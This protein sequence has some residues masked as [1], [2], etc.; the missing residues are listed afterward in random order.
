MSGQDEYD[1]LEELIILGKE[2]GYLSSDEVKDALPENFLRSHNLD[3]ILLFLGAAGIE[4]LDAERQ[5]EVGRG[6]AVRKNANGGNNSR[7]EFE[8][9]GKTDDPVRL[10][11]REM[12]TVPLLN[13]EAEIE[14]AK[15][16]EKAQIN[17]L[18]AVSRSPLAVRE[19]LSC[20]QNLRDRKIQ[21]TKLVNF[22]KD[23]LID[24]IL[25][26]RQSE[27]HERISRVRELQAK[28][29]EVRKQLRRTSQD[30]PEYEK[31]L[32]QLACYRVRIVRQIRSL[33]L[34]PEIQARLVGVVRIAVDGVRALEREQKQLLELQKSPLPVARATQVK[35]RLGQ[36]KKELLAIDDELQTTSGELKR[37]FAT[38]RRFELEEDIAKKE[39][40]EANLRLVVSIAKKYARR[41]VL[42]LDLIQEGNIGLM[43]AVDK[44]D[45]RRGYKFSTY[46]H[47]WIRQAITRAI[48]D[49]S[50]TIRLPVHM[51]ER[52]NKLIQTSRALLQQG[53]R[54]PTLEELAHET[55]IPVAQVR[56]ALKVAQQ[57]ISLETP[58][59]EDQDS[60]LGS[61]VEDRLA[62][63]PADLTIGIDLK[64]QTSAMLQTLT[65]REE[66]ILRMRYGIDDGI[67]CTLEEVGQRF[68]VTRERIRQIQDKALRKLRYLSLGKE[69]TRF[70][71]PSDRD[72]RPPS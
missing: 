55:G 50:R 56:Q 31:L 46:A 38:I 62:I 36:I 44:F 9:P 40:V 21:I 53:G 51:T 42:F 39:L 18:K 70:P 11:M 19:I 27:T 34:T 65:S 8:D 69:R 57:T 5:S 6:K 3:Q 41:G 43:R 4:V 54:E 32:S 12:G 68:S 14:L 2:K 23:E 25:A 67:E 35:N 47:W 13:R 22:T 71:K 60:H 33:K 16:I 63:S 37:T 30:S 66:Q 61:L 7:P 64:E 15:R 28:T 26:A 59:G 52:V 49:Q 72:A 17:V 1:V 45:Y 20:D 10:Y 48:A 29:S 58:I 24:D